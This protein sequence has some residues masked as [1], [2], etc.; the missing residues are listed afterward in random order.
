MVTD[1]ENSLYCYTHEDGLQ[2]L[3]VQALA[4]NQIK[5]TTGAGDAFMAGFLYGI[6]YQKSIGQSLQ[7]GYKAAIEIIHRIGCEVPATR[8][9]FI[10]Y[11]WNECVYRKYN[12][13]LSYTVYTFYI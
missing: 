11:K 13:L 5:D 1:G 7:I 2:I 6:C 10:D 4:V 3:P 8:P 12:A 9:T